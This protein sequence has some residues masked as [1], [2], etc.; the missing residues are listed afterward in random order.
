VIGHAELKL[1]HAAPQRALMWA[2]PNNDASNSAND[3]SNASQW[4]PERTIRAALIRWLAADPQARPYVHP[5]GLGIG[6]A[7]IDG[8]LDLSYLTLYTP[9]TI[10]SSSIPEGIDFSFGHLQGLDLSRDETGPI[11]GD[12]ATI[13]GDLQLTGGKYGPVSADRIT[14]A[15]D[16]QMT[17]GDFVR[18]A[19]LLIDLL[20]QVGDAASEPA[21]SRAARVAAD[22]IFRGVVSAS[23]VLDGE[24]EPV[25]EGDEP[26]PERDQTDDQTDELIDDEADADPQG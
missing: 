10:I 16:L 20:R 5:S 25:A 17:G 15:G 14:I 3:P 21:T 26:S 1:V 8:Q 2:G 12:R 23:S 11:T 6:G 7:K 4:P 18:N 13:A 24:D 19:K 9:L 22:L